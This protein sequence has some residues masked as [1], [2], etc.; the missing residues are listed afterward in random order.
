MKIS[1]V[2]MQKVRKNV[3]DEIL[4]TEIDYMANLEFL[5]NVRH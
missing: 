1:I 4:R 2:E 5:I 3:A